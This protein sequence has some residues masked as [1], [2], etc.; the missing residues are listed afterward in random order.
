MTFD[1]HDECTNHLYAPCCHPC[2]ITWTRTPTTRYTILSA[3]QVNKPKQ[4]SPLPPRFVDSGTY[5]GHPTTKLQEQLNQEIFSGGT[6]G[7]DWKDEAPPKQVS[8]FMDLIGAILLRCFAFW[9]ITGGN[10]SWGV[11]SSQL[12]LYVPLVPQCVY[13]FPFPPPTSQHHVWSLS[14]NGRM[15]CKKLYFV[16]SGWRN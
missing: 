8:L 6:L 3:T 2:I 14:W 11:K 1:E 4:L 9:K 10:L 5:N 12:L 16:C 15:S 7:P 13:S